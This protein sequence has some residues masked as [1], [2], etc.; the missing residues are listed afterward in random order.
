MSH[1]TAFGLQ[2]IL[3]VSYLKVFQRNFL[4]ISQRT[5]NYQKYPTFQMTSSKL[6]H[7]FVLLSA[8]IIWVALGFQLDVSMAWAK[9]RG[10]GVLAGLW[11]YM[12][13]FTN[14]SNMMAGIAL[15]YALRVGC[16][17][18]R[19]KQR[20]G[21]FAAITLF[22]CMAGMVFYLEISQHIPR[23]SV[24]FWINVVL[25][26]VN[27]TLF[28]AFWLFLVPRGMLRFRDAVMWLIFPV[29]YFC[30]VMLRGIL[31]GQYPY[32]FFNP[33][34]LGYKSVVG[35]GLEMLA[36]FLS[37]GLIVVALDRLK[38]GAAIWRE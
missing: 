6:K 25:H 12:S 30:Y 1:S 17:P 4:K 35:N 37:F 18:L 33:A 10:F 13:F 8:V 19:L 36:G 34:L 31:I 9:N 28:M 27:P 26:Y 38:P 5:R 29:L 7:S 16:D 2:K 11:S 22:I 24:Y 3:S 21:H 32:S 23:H 20:A 14:L 15:V